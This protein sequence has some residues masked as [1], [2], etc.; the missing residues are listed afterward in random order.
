MR[1]S[2][3]FVSVIVHAVVIAAAL[4]AQVLAVGPLPIPR[5]PLTFIGSMPIRV[6]DIPLPPAAPHAATPPAPAQVSPSAAPIEA[7][8]E[9]RSETGREGLAPRINMGVVEGGVGDSVIAGNLVQLPPPPPPPTPAPQGP[10]RISNG[11][12][13]P[14]R[15]VNVDP[16]YPRVAQAAHIEGV[17]ILEATIDARGR[18]I[19]VRVLRSMP[20]LDQAA[21]DAVRQWIYTPTLLNGV[22]VPI[23]MTVT[24]TFKLQDR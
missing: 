14:R 6:I 15:V 13:V 18:V 8:S 11:M 5:A 17:V 16:V 21:V 1:R 20:L 19:D 10:V 4:I 2:F 9:I 7:P 3:T 24:V 23:V 22:P 12:R